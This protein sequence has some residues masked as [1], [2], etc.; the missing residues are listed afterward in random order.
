MLKTSSGD[1]VIGN[2]TTG[3]AIV[4]GSTITSF[5]EKVFE[6]VDGTPIDADVSS[7]SSVEAAANQI[8]SIS[9]SVNSTTSTRAN[10]LRGNEMLADISASSS[11]SSELRFPEDWASISTSITVSSN[12][13]AQIIRPAELTFKGFTLDGY[14]C[15]G[16]M[17]TKG[18]RVILK[19]VYP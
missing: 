16:I 1:L 3:G 11:V 4:F 14:F 15:N 9:A 12:V 17:D 13:D 18:R 8:F 7:A 6:Y 5:G 2:V 10:G 19:T